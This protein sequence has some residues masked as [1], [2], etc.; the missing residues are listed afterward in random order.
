MSCSSAPQHEE[1]SAPTEINGEGNKKKA[2]KKK[3]KSQSKREENLDEFSLYKVD[4]SES[5]GRH[6]IATQ[7]ISQ[8]TC[9]LREKPFDYISTSNTLCSICA[10]YSHPQQ[11]D[12]NYQ[13]YYV[14]SSACA[15]LYSQRTSLIPNPSLIDDISSLCDCDPNLIRA[16][17]S[18]FTRLLLDQ[19]G[20]GDKLWIEELNTFRATSAGFLSQVSH[21]DQQSSAWRSAVGRACHQI[22]SNLY[23]S[24][25]LSTH[26]LSPFYVGKDEDNLTNIAVEIA[27]RIN[28]NSYGIVQGPVEQ[29]VVA[30]VGLFPIAAMCFNH[31]C[32]PS[33][34]HIFLD[35]AMEYRA[36]RDIKVGEELCVSYIDCT[37]PCSLRRELLLAS[38]YFH[39]ACVRCSSVDKLLLQSVTPLP[40][41]D[42]QSSTA[43]L[44][45][46]FVSVLCV[47][48]EGRSAQAEIMLEGLYCEQCGTSVLMCKSPNIFSL[49]SLP[50]VLR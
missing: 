21:L 6:A 48:E 40:R 26:Q 50:M 11:G 34:V 16:T 20:V 14:C 23:P 32:E 5:C 36:I 19:D 47:G 33:L 13:P 4:S 24:L 35:G 30:G 27:S 18:V 41:P 39:C 8:G 29:R 44:E 31:S 42:S 49:L 38:R 10:R 1:H 46:G 25:T 9:V 37:L 15:E 43:S 22:I 45:S 12:K 28:V 17:F 7:P 3:K 2:R